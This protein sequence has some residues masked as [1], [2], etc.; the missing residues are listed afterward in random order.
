MLEYYIIYLS[1][2]SQFVGMVQ[3]RAIR[4]DTED[5][6][7]KVAGRILTFLDTGWYNADA[8]PS[9]LGSPQ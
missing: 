1:A 3:A 2:L 5:R 9:V 7:K 4:H 8:V 6:F